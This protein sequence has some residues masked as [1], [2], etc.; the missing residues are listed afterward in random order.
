MKNLEQFK[1][2]K[3][4]MNSISGEKSYACEA[5]DVGLNGFYEGISFEITLND[6]AESSTYQDAQ[7]VLQRQL[8]PDFEITCS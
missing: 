4:Q 5:N 3:N 7:N 1:L 2:S 6:F 8:G